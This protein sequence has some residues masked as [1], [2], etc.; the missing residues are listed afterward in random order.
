M[1]GVSKW[2]TPLRTMVRYIRRRIRYDAVF[3]GTPLDI[4]ISHQ[5][6]HEK[7]VEIVDEPAVPLRPDSEQLWSRGALAQYGAP[8]GYRVPREGFPA[9]R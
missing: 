7:G 2:R 9:V 3:R 8:W 1:F 5:R 6:E 4:H